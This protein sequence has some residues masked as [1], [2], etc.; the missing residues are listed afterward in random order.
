MPSRVIARSR[1][2][3]RL[4]EAAGEG[5]LDDLLGG[6]PD[7][8]RITVHCYVS[9]GCRL[10]VNG[11]SHEPLNTSDADYRKLITFDGI[12]LKKGRN[13]CLIKLASDSLAGDQPGTLAVRMTSNRR[14][15]FR[16]LDSAIEREG[17]E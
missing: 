8:P 7:A 6:G 13:R 16:Q 14:E 15:Y 17:T 10:F 9:S 2:G 4:R 3:R 5:A 12:P 11:K 1:C